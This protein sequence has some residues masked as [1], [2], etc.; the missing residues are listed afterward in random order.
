MILIKEKNK[1]KKYPSRK[2]KALRFLAIHKQRETSFEKAILKEL[3]RQK[4]IVL[5][6]FDDLT[7]GKTRLPSDNDLAKL[8]PTGEIDDELTKIGQLHIARGYG[9]GVEETRMETV[10]EKQLDFVFEGL[11][12]QTIQQIIST[13]ESTFGTDYWKRLVN[14][15]TR[16]RL[17][18]LILG[19]IKE[20][21]GPVQLSSL[22][23]QDPSGLFNADRALAI[24]RTETTGALNGGAWIERQQLLADGA[25]DGTEW[26]STIDG[27]TRFS[28]VVADEQ[29]IRQGELFRVGAEQAPYPAWHGL[30]A[31][32]RVH[33]RCSSAS[34]IE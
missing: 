26:L 1:R 34:V 10:I 5:D 14:N 12:E 4:S 19:S 28:H 23:E 33:C 13:V 7:S 24:A 16:S 20:G 30:S 8:L 3:E 21:L 6:N 17:R 2:R 9:Q 32:E 27:V 29:I 15:H 22:I 18:S 25:I 11:D 31:K